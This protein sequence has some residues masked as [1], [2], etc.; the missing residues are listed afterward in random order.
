MSRTILAALACATLIG[1][2][3]PGPGRGVGA[4]YTPI[5]D[6]AGVDMSRY[7]ADLA[8]CQQVA[9]NVDVGNEALA[10]AL[11]GAAAAAIASSIVRLDWRDTRSLMGGTAIGGA[12]NYAGRA[13]SRQQMVV[14]NCMAGRGYRTLDGGAVS[15]VVLMQPAA[16]SIAAQGPAAAAAPQGSPY[17][18]AAAPGPV[19]QESYQVERMAEVKACSAAPR[20]TLTGKG[21][22]FELYSVPCANG[23][24]LSV[25]CEFGACRVLR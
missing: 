15:Q 2:A 8:A 19:G 5:I 25:R 20:A 21:P 13:E 1:C 18:A 11:A 3:G 23:D 7:G 16:A 10:G 4:R 9:R 24:S 22:G 17:V 14:I 6:T 12:A